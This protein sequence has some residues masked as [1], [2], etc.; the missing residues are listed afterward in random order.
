MHLKPTAGYQILIFIFENINV[1]IWHPA[2]GLRRIIPPKHLSQL[3]TRAIP[4]I[5]PQE[6][7]NFAVLDIFFMGYL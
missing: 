4:L 1:D 7:T 5:K 6:G 2:V 3:Y